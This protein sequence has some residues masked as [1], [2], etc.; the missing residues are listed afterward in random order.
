MSNKPI[1]LVSGSNIEKIKEQ[2]PYSIYN[3]CEGVF[4]SMA[5]E[6]WQKE[7]LIY[8]QEF[9]MDP[10]LKEMLISFQMYT[11]FPIKPKVGGR[12]AIIEERPGMINFTTIGRNTSIEE[13]NR[14]YKK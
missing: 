3:R 14:Y 13:R 4:A 5:N 1:F 10:F 6:L 8:Q 11:K 9:N 2:I 7:H 12:G